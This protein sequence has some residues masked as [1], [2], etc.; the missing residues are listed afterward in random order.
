MYLIT[1]ILTRVRGI[2]RFCF[3]DITLNHIVGG[4]YIMQYNRPII[5]LMRRKI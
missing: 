1:V 5:K 2:K 3:T 4:I